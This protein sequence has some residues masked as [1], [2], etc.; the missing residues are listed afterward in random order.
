[1]LPSFIWRVGKPDSS[2]SGSP[3]KGRVGASYHRPPSISTANNGRPRHLPQHQHQDQ[4]RPQQHRPHHTYPPQ[5][6]MFT[7]SPQQNAQH[8][9][10]SSSA[11][12][13]NVDPAPE[14][15]SHGDRRI[16]VH[17]QGEC[18]K[19]AILT[20]CLKLTSGK[21]HLHV[22][23]LL[24]QRFSSGARLGDVSFVLSG[25]PHDQAK[26]TAHAITGAVAEAVSFILADDSY[27]G[28]MQRESSHSSPY[29]SQHSST[30]ADSTDETTAAHSHA[31]ATATP[32]N[33]GRCASHLRNASLDSAKTPKVLKTRIPKA[34]ED[35]S[36]SAKTP[37]RW[38]ASA[39]ELPVTAVMLP[40][41]PRI[42]PHVCF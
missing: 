21:A 13:A 30:S 22:R 14:A 35:L 2:S 19:E 17:I 25:A 7:P 12:A 23:K 37:T 1:M 36:Q 26:E 8:Q 24:M 40:V 28:S 32:G 38:T 6:Q 41:Y 29:T 34:K 9:V 20:R 10:Q 31:E 42:Y 11:N 16:E 15:R 18:L 39:K 3:D 4:Q 27:G 33:V 5:Q